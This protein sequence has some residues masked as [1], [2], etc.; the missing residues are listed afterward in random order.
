MTMERVILDITRTAIRTLAI[1]GTPEQPA[2]RHIRVEPVTGGLNA[3]TIRRALQGLSRVRTKTVIVTIPREDVMVRAGG[4]SGAIPF[5]FPEEQLV[6]EA[7]EGQMVACQRTRLQSLLALLQ[8]VGW[9]P[10]LITPASWGLWAWF[11]RVMDDSQV[12]EPTA[13]LHLDV[14]RMDLIVA[15]GGRLVFSRGLPDID[16][17]EPTLKAA[18]SVSPERPIGRLVL[19][20]A[21]DL[22]Q[23]KCLLAR[24]LDLP[25][26][27]H[28]MPQAVPGLSAAHEHGA[29]F[30]VAWGLATAERQWLVNL[31]PRDVR[32][33]RHRRVRLRQS[34]LTAMVGCLV[35]A[36]GDGLIAGFARREAHLVAEANEALRQWDSTTGHL[37]QQEQ[38]L[39]VLEAMLASRHAIR[40]TL[41]ELFRVTPADVVYE[42]L[43]FDR[44]RHELAVRGSTAST[45]QVFEYLRLLEQSPGWGQA[46]LRYAIARRTSAGIRTDFEILL[47]GG[48][49][50][51]RR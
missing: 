13:V 27:V 10:E 40:T 18:A 8:E 38:S 2:I 16:E 4:A 22:E 30:V 12:R 23:W 47:A 42:E 49:S 51:W 17:L 48:V 20:G 19:T 32:Q 24:R 25:I 3:E 1:D 5:P 29:S 9:E 37:A 34:V 6:T 36:L 41:V 15:S 28:P 35:L 21:G 39:A 46:V 50:S 26:V 44:T 45:A 11:H 31:V 43:S 33:A 7:Q 14:D